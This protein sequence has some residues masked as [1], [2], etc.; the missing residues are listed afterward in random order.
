[1]RKHNVEVTL[2]PADLYLLDEALEVLAGVEPAKLEGILCVARKLQSSE[3]AKKV[4]KTI[5]AYKHL[6]LK[7][8]E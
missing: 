1:M 6:Q 7:L 2:S 5:E 3:L 8:P 4:V